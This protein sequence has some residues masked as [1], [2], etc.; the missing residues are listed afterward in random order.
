MLDAISLKLTEQ[1]LDHV[2]TAPFFAKD[3][4]LKY[5][6][7]NQTMAELCGVASPKRLVGLTAGDLF[8]EALRARFEEMDRRVIRS[9]RPLRDQL[10]FVESLRGRRVWLHYAR[11]PIVDAS[12]RVLGVVAVARQLEPTAKQRPSY[13]RVHKVVTCFQNDIAGGLDIKA[14][15]NVLSVSVSQL[16]RDFA[17]VFGVSPRRYLIKTRFEAAL[18]ML[19]GERSVTEIAHACGYKDQSAFARQFR[20]AVGSSPT[21]YRKSVHPR[22]KEMPRR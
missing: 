7:A 22:I 21:A 4:S 5:V 1:L 17:A 20:A 6:A 2:P 11:W 10:E 19:A 18:D 16:E 12:R 15:A 3:T 9:G 13:E 14:H 8:P